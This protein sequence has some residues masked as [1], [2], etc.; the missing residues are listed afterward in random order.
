MFLK[1]YWSCNLRF[2]IIS[3]FPES[4]Q[5]YFEHG[6][7][8]Q[9]QRKNLIHFQYLQLR[10]YAEDKY[11]T[12]DDRPFGGGDGM[13]LKADILEKALKYV[14]RIP[15]YKIYL[16]P[17]GKKLDD[18]MV[19]RLACENTS[20]T[21][22][23]G[24]YAGVDERFLSRHID[25]EVSVGDFVMS[26]GELP[27]MCLIDAVARQITGVLGNQDSAKNESFHSNLLEAPQFTR[28]AKFREMPVPEVLLSGDHK[29]IQKWR[30]LLSILRTKQRRPDLFER[31]GIPQK[32]LEEALQLYSQMSSDER[33]LC[34][35]RD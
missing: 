30:Y 28:P 11:G 3:L 1:I 12:V 8:A 24:R 17:Q 9:A 5:T 33:S 4:F 20:I 32:D 26:G 18:A 34:G 2:H 27:A 25:E 22:I 29:K 35:L 16:S 14:D 15:S 19:K 7:L 23:C 31:S 10:N 6:I 13:L 21:L